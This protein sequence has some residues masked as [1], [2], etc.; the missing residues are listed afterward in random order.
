MKYDVLAPEESVTKTINALN[1]KGIQTLTVEN[2]KAALA[3][4][5]ELIPT[6]VSVMNGSSTTLKQIGFIEYLKTGTHG[7]DN[8][9]EKVLAEKDPVKQSILRKHATVSDYYV[10]SV[11]ALTET[12]EFIVASNSGSQLASI[13]Y[14]SPNLLFIV[15]TQKIVPSLPEGMK[16]LETYVFHREDNR[17][18][19]EYG[20]GTMLSKVL[21]FR[22]ENSMFGRKIKFVFVKEILGF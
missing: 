3:K 7:W 10:G 8:L 13:V 15:G 21:I 17:M 14:N 9:H 1:T 22:G 5:K 2:K 12:G 11:H 20:V 18:K 19:E 4:I 16:R 6:G